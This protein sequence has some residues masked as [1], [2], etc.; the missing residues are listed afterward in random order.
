MQNGFPGSQVLQLY[1]VYDLLAG[2]IMGPLMALPNDAVAL[3]VLRDSLSAD[4]PMTRNPRDFALFKVGSVDLA[5][6]KLESAGEFPCHPGLALIRADVMLQGMYADAP[7]G[8][9]LD[10][11]D[12]EVPDANG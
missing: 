8:P 12:Q 6:G 11:M 9:Q 4:T 5:S 2:M 3:R 10:L 1:C 7:K